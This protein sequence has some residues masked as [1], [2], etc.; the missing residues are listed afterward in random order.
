MEE[1]EPTITALVNFL[2]EEQREFAHFPSYKIL[3]KKLD[4]FLECKPEEFQFKQTELLHAKM[5]FD[6][7]CNDDPEM[8]KIL[9]AKNKREDIRKKNEHLDSLNSKETQ[10]ILKDYVI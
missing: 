5:I 1:K 10:K 7:L 6:N 2:P 9:L 8:I 3:C 4:E